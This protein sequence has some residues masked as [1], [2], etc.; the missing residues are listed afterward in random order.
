M[1]A[2]IE[3]IKSRFDEAI[4]QTENLFRIF[5][6]IQQLRKDLTKEEFEEIKGYSEFQK[7]LRKFNLLYN[8]EK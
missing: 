5:E 3:N 1:N 8:I 2:K 7:S 6:E 4:Y